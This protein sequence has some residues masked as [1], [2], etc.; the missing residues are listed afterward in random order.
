MI[1][2]DPALLGPLLGARLVDVQS[3]AMDE[4]E[5]TGNDSVTL[6]FDNGYTVTFDTPVGFVI[7]TP[8][9]QP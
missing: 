1:I 2:R 8:E 9:A 4:L 3:N 6:C 5:E 7:N